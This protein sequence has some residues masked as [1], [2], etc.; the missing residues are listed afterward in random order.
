MKYTLKLDDTPYTLYRETGR[1]EQRFYPR[2]FDEYF[3]ERYQ[4]AF[5]MPKKGDLPE[6]YKEFSDYKVRMGIPDLEQRH[7]MPVS[8]YA[9]LL[10][11]VSPADQALVPDK[12][13]ALLNELAKESLEIANQALSIA[14]KSDVSEE[15]KNELERFVTD[16][17]LYM[18][19]TEVMIHK[20]QAEF[21]SE[22]YL[23]GN[24]LMGSHWKDVG[25]KEFQDDLQMQHE[26]LKEFEN[27][28]N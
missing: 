23:H 17:K 19:S 2:P 15:N 3:F 11:E 10:E 1:V 9:I 26:W 16:S 20:E 28:H 5:D 27:K 14:K 18:L 25:L 8:Q 21:T 6:M 7:C 4:E 12:V 13:I 24:D 22:T